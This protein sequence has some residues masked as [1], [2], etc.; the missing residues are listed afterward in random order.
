M[1]CLVLSI[2]VD[3]GNNDKQTN[4]DSE[5]NKNNVVKKEEQE[6]TKSD[7]NYLQEIALSS[8]SLDFNKDILDYDVTVLNE[9]SELE[10]N[11]K[12]LDSKATVNGNG[13][14]KL[15]VGNN[16]IKLDVTAENGEIKEYTI[17]VLRKEIDKEDLLEFLKENLTE[18][19]IPYKI[20]KLTKIP[21]TSNDKVDKKKLPVD[22]AVMPEKESSLPETELEEKLLK[23]LKKVL[24]VSKAG[25]D[26]NFFD[27]GGDSL[28]AMKFISAIRNE[29]D[30]SGIQLTDILRYPNIRELA[31][32]VNLNSESNL[33][34][35]QTGSD[36]SKKLF[37]IHGGNASAD[38]YQELI[39]DLGKVYTYYGIDYPDLITLEPREVSYYKLAESYTEE[40]IRSSGVEEEYNLLGWCIGGVI[41]F[42][43]ALQLENKYG[44]KVNVIM[45]DS[46][47]PGNGQKNNFTPEMEEKYLKNSWSV[48]VHDDE[49]KDSR[50]F[51]KAVIQKAD[52][53]EAVKSRI[54][55]YL[56]NSSV[57]EIVDVSSMDLEELIM[58]NN[59][60]R[61]FSYATGNYVPSGIL[62]KGKVT[63]I[64]AGEGSAAL[65]PQNWEKWCAGKI[66]YH[67]INSNHFEILN[68]EPAKIC[69]E[70]I[71]S[72]VDK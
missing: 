8:G 61:S 32:N 53:K 34:L 51:W 60:F 35:L 6:A 30:I 18:Y 47:E 9:V 4:Q 44:K 64:E 48:E 52:N 70:I 16:L 21:L 11:A 71:K 38:A 26:D 55:E 25:I 69:S 23:V 46:Q 65:N 27:L 22:M 54:Q 68:K 14:Y 20:I 37:F 43:V 57:D 45:L 66:E 31:E 33:R 19:M 62:E 7:N 40:I 59:L 5:N 10:V 17:N 36:E 2:K 50:E 41:A 72:F 1:K 56:K 39:G 29:E 63:Y 28:S 15:E 12:T 13:I 49:V 42:E 58:L 67:Q 24:K 3:N